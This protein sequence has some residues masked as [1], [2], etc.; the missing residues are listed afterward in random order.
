MILGLDV[1]GTQT[2]AVLL[3]RGGVLVETKTPTG[4]ARFEARRSAR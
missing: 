3:D 1:G 4:D 2:D